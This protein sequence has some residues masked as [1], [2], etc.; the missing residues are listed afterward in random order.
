MGRIVFAVAAALALWGFAQA[1]AAGPATSGPSAS[2]ADLA[3][4]D[5]A[6]V[7][8][9]AA[10]FAKAAKEHAVSLLRPASQP[11]SN[12]GPA[13]KAELARLARDYPRLWTLRMQDGEGLPFSP[14]MEDLV[15]KVRALADANSPPVAPYLRAAGGFLKQQE[16]VDRA[17]ACEFLAHFPA[18]TVEQGL[19]GGVGECLDDPAAVFEAFSVNIPQS[20]ALPPSIV[21]MPMNVGQIAKIAAA[22]ITGLSFPSRNVFKQWWRGSG[23]YAR[24]LWYW[25]ARWQY[26]APDN[27]LP[28]LDTLDPKDALRIMLLTNNRVAISQEAGEPRRYGGEKN[29]PADLPGV[30]QLNEVSLSPAVIAAFAKKHSMKDDLLGLY[31]E[32]P[33]WLKFSDKDNR[34]YYS[35]MLFGV[36]RVLGHL[37]DKEDLPAVEAILTGKTVQLSLHDSLMAHVALMGAGLAP[38]NAE[39]LLVDQLHRTP[40]QSDL[41][42]ELVKVSGLKHLDLVKAAY[43]ASART[44]VIDQ[45]G[46][47]KSK[48][49]AKALGELLAADDLSFSENADRQSRHGNDEGT[50]EAIFL[51]YVRAAEAING[52]PVIDKELV[53]NARRQVG[54]GASPQMNHHNKPVGPFRKQAIEELAQFFGQQ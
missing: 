4:L 5:K 21:A 27:D 31:Y 15:A 43:N 34:D 22:N 25:R 38:A 1:E 20:A 39:R 52:K 16:A 40:G 50:R 35:K 8:E 47:L 6:I 7:D 3:G 9:V 41:A 45:I 28:A 30:F 37:L 36:T 18:Q 33:A 2:P 13:E 19:L 29:R 42:A 44:S 51:A 53:E 23:D 10:A 14:A 54:K 24:T 49:A 17:M 32:S 26:V 46:A 48:P 12:P 11:S